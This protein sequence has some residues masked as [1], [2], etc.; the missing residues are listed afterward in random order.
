VNVS[1]DFEKILTYLVENKALVS[2]NEKIY[3]FLIANLFKV[4]VIVSLPPRAE[5]W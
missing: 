1:D 5:V 3:F 2:Q 4:E